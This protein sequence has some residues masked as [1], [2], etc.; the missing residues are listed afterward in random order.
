MLHSLGNSLTVRSDTFIVRSIGESTNPLGEATIRVGFEAVVQ[1]V[2]DWTDPSDPPEKTPLA[3]L[4]EINQAFGRR[5]VVVAL[6]EI[7]L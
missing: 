3:A 6:R 2:P 5:F 1:R 7:D 4:S